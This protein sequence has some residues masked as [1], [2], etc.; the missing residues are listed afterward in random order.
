MAPVGAKINW[1]TYDSHEDFNISD[2]INFR[3]GII[4]YYYLLL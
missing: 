1:E 3:F 4:R 2:I